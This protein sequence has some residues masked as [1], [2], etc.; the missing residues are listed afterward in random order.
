MTGLTPSVFASKANQGPFKGKS[1]RQIAQLKIDQRRP[2][3]LDIQDKPLVLGVRIQ[4]SSL[5]YV[6]PKSKTVKSISFS[7]VIKDEDFGGSPP[8]ASKKGSKLS[9]KIVEVMSEAFFCIYCAMQYKGTLNKYIKDE[10]YLEWNDIQKATELKEFL[11]TYKISAVVGEEVNSNVFKQYLSNADNFLVVNNWHERLLSQVNVFFGKEKLATGQWTFL[12]ADNLKL[13]MDP[14]KTFDMV[15]SKIKTTVGFN[16]PI[17][18]DKWNPGDVWFFS[19][20]AKLKLETELKKLN[21]LI[22][23][24]PDSSVGYLNDLN[25][26]IYKLYQKNQLYPIS[27]KAPSGTGAKIESVNEDSD[28]EQIVD[29]TKVDLD[30]GNSDVKLRFD[31]VYRNKKTKKIKK[32][33]TGFLKMKTDSG[34]FR[35]EMEVPGSGARFGSI[36]TEN[37]QYIIYNTDKSGIDKLQ[38]IRNRSN[39]YKA[40]P[41]N[42]RAGQS[43]LQWLGASPYMKLE[44]SQ[45]SK[46][47]ASALEGYLQTLFK[48]INNE[49]F[50]TYSGGKAPPPDKQILNKTVASEI[51]TAIDG[52]NSSTTKS[53]TVEN[54]YNL[55]TSQGFSVG[56]SEAQL[57][58]R[59]TGKELKKESK[60]IMDTSIAETLFD[61]CFYLKVF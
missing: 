38:N 28:I 25:Q 57:K 34:G 2:F 45:G 52:I 11:S 12:R 48:K 24:E 16:K 58:A 40:I 3:I 56:V 31:V 1:R 61:S 8:K 23:K 53:I 46:A 35:L 17:D 43:E 55:A 39:S 49:T 47:M 21:N 27:L 33:K 14:Y 50:K 51:A 22:A 42:F 7:K 32:T 15:S 20:T 9:G 29:F 30:Q 59:L 19:S 4:G 5:S 18:K 54:M 6:L 60:Q 44:K 10:T 13:N 36:G 26:L 41:S 37:Y